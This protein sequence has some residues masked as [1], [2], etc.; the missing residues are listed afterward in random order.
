M[1]QRQVASTDSG[2]WLGPQNS[3]QGHSVLLSCRVPALRQGHHST[4]AGPRQGLLE[5]LLASQC[6]SVFAFKASFGVHETEF[7]LRSCLL[8]FPMYQTKLIL[9]SW[10][11]TIVSEPEN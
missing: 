8:Q 10:A 4:A 11:R 5:V 9:L 6:S 2:T 7:P 3:T 1:F